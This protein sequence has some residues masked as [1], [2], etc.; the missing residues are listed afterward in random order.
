MDDDNGDNQGLGWVL[1]GGAAVILILML[2]GLGVLLGWVR[3][4]FIG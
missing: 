3:V 1:A 2:L 4:P